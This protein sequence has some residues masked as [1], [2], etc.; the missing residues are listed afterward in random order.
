M[1]QSTALPRFDL[2]TSGGGRLTSDA[3]H[4]HRTILYFYPKDDT[5]GCT[6]E[7]Q[8][9]TALASQFRAHDVAV[10]GVSPDS[11][12]S[13]EKFITKC[14]LGIPLVSDPDHVLIDALNLW[15]EKT[16]MGRSYQGVQRSTFLIG[17]DGAIEREWRAV[18]APGHAA[19][20]LEAVA[21]A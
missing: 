16:Y 19:E 2:A 7:S 3:L 12:R 6:L 20:V 4:G 9:F 15:V 21:G 13:H 10:F 8:E 14:S 17:P 1:A 18:K 11:E 5:P